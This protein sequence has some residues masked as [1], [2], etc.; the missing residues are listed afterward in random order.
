MRPNNFMDAGIGDLLSFEYPERNLIGVRPVWKRRLLLVERIIDTMTEPIDPR[1]VELAP[2]TRRG[3]YLLHGHDLH[4]ERPRSFYYEA[5]RHVRRQAWLQ[6]ALFN[7]CEEEVIPLCPK[8]PFAPTRE[9]RQFLA[10]VIRHYNRKAAHRPNVRHNVG[11]F[12][13]EGRRYRPRSRSRPA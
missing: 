5:M 2:L 3:R 9:D 13:V 7:P 1:A 6:L 4:L 8:G 10:E 12:P 11:V